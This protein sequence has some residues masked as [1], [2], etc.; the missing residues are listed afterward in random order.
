MFTT[1]IV[2]MTASNSFALRKVYLPAIVSSFAAGGFD[3][4]AIPKKY[5]T[6]S[7]DLG[8]KLAGSSLIQNKRTSGIYGSFAVAFRNISNRPQSVKLVLESSQFR[9]ANWTISEAGLPDDGF[10]RDFTLIPSTAFTLPAKKSASVSIEFGCQGDSPVNNCFMQRKEV[11]IDGA[12][13]LGIANL[14]GSP[15]QSNAA[16]SGTPKFLCYELHTTVQAMIEVT[17]DSGA[18]IGSVTMNDFGAAHGGAETRLGAAVQIE[19]N[20]GRAF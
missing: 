18:I 3:T 4:S 8:D 16:A 14:F 9:V 2:L 15:W 20:G 12:P 13:I 17:E 7:F 11:S 10:T 19:I 1:L 6:L 5:C